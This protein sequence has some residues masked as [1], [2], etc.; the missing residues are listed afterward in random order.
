MKAMNQ[1]QSRVAEE[2]RHVLAP[3]LLRGDIP[4][5]LPTSR[6]TV[7]DVWV[8]S[9]LRNARVYLALP[10]E[11]DAEE[12]LATANAQLAAPLRKVLAKGLATKY[13]PAVTF[14]RTEG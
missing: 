8:S 7:T 11:L 6:L 14:F 3:A 9:D 5:T 13:I 10:E 2:V 1:R 4:S 12:T